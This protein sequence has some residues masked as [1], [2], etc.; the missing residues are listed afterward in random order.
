MNIAWNLIVVSHMNIHLWGFNGAKQG[1]N[2]N[3][4]QGAPFGYHL[5]CANRSNLARWNMPSFKTTLWAWNGPGWPQ[6]GSE[7][8][9]WIKTT[10]GDPKKI[11][12]NLAGSKCGWELFIFCWGGVRRKGRV[13]IELGVLMLFFWSIMFFVENGVGLRY[14]VFHWTMIMEERVKS[15][16]PKFNIAPKKWWLE[17]D[18]FL[19]GLSFFRGYVSFR[20]L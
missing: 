10:Q 7:L 3:A 13:R 11:P 16:P 2:S 9:W 12:T 20:L 17:D 6:V 18:P 19:L 1:P 4:K 8:R 5:V 15:K 14:H